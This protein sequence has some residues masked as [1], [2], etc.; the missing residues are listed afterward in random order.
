MVWSAAFAALLLTADVGPVSLHIDSGAQITLAGRDAGRQL[1][2]SGRLADGSLCDLTAQARYDVVPAAVVAVDNSGYVTALREGKATVTAR[3]GVATVEVE[4]VVT[5]V[6]R[7]LPVNFAND[8]VPIFTRFGCN[9][10]GCHGKSGGQNGFALSLLG[11]EPAEDYEYIVKEARG[12]RLL[13]GAAESSLLLRKATGSM[14]HGGGSKLPADSAAYRVLRRWLEQ[15]APYGRAD[16]PHVARIEV[17]PRERLLKP[18]AAQQ[19]AVLA[20]YSDGTSRDVT[21]LSQFESNDA[22]V[23]EVSDSGL[24][25]TRPVP[26]LAAVM[27]RF[28]PHVDLIRATVPRGQ[29]VA[30]LLPAQNFI[31]KLVFAQLERLGVPASPLCDDATF[32]RR[33]TIDIA[34]RLPT[35]DEVA[36]FQAEPGA[37]RRVKLVERLLASPDYADYFA[38]KW[39]AVLRNKRESIKD[40][41]RPTF[42]FHAW[43]KEHLHANR[44]FDEL[45][46]ALLTAT[47]EEVQNPPVTWYREVRDLPAQAEDTAQLFLGTRLQCAR[48]HHHPQERWS[49]ADYFGYAAFFAQLAYKPPPPEEKGKKKAKDAPKPLVQIFHK[50]GVAAAKNPRTGL[51]VKPTL[52]GG[53]VAEVAADADPRVRLAEWIV[54]PDNPYFARA[55][56]NRYWKHFLGRGLVEPE[57]DLRITNP[58]TNPELLDALARHFVAHRH[59]LKDLV[60][61][62]CTSAAYQLS[63]S[64]RAGNEADRQSYSHFRPRR[65]HAEVLF[66]AIDQVTLS[67]PQ[68]AGVPPGTRAVQLPDNAFDSYFLTLF[69]RPDG[70]SACECERSSEVNLAQSL[71]LMNSYEILTKV[72]GKQQAA[73]KEKKGAAKASVR[74][75]PGERLSRLLADKRAA[76]EVLS[77]LYVAALSRR[78]TDEEMTVLTAYVAERRSD[79]RGAYEDILWA[80]I[81]S[82]EFLFNH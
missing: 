21:R 58:P 17:L 48:C 78:P 80:L 6:A 67:Q 43:I 44:P 49:Q 33:V 69:G 46:R 18:E 76:A 39:R 26:G 37:D 60:R 42:A 10:G 27:V 5:N 31:D 15:G 74:A 29:S 8:V 59:D 1:L 11:F 41:P 3:S 64:S 71:H 61:T 62:I 47:G 57:D 66:D 50:E 77:D 23:A 45:V 54:H 72:S 65:L 14:A 81:N 56:V 2:L 19:L 12:R 79:L 51:A 13:P 20:H 35:P 16:D 4:V 22:D 52:L 36:Q 63:S 25:R 32:L 68:F 7:D 53:A 38:S 28:Q 70:A 55:L 9:A 73:A 40:D 24:V 30:E 82:E 34:G 75:T